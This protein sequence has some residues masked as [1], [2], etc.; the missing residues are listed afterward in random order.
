MQQSV[1]RNNAI[2]ENLFFLHS[3]IGTAVHFESVEL[4]KRPFIQKFVDPFTG[5][6]FSGIVLLFDSVETTAFHCF[7]IFFLEFFE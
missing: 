3:E 7:L 1:A 2:T 6:E 5:G 4:N